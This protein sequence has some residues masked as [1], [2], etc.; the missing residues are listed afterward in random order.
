[1]RGTSGAN[2]ISKFL[3]DGEINVD[4]LMGFGGSRRT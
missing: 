1:M 3:E 2:K 4:L